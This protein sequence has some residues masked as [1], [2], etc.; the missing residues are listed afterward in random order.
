MDPR[1]PS[2]LIVLKSAPGANDAWPPTLHGTGTEDY[3]NTAWCPT[4][5]YSAPYHGI[6][7]GGGPNWTE[8]VT[9]YRWHIED[10]VIFQKQIRVTIEH[11]HANRRSDDISSVAFWYQAEP[12]KPFDPLPPVADRVPGFRA[13][14]RNMAAADKE[15]GR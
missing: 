13:P 6:I 7:A 12:H 5:E 14:F 15:R 4:Q 3:F 1:P 10:P 11:G 9:L 8:P 2:C